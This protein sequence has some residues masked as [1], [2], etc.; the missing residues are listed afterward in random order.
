MARVK[1]LIGRRPI[2]IEIDGGV[3]PDTTPLVMPG[4]DILVA[5]SAVFKGGKARY[6][7]NID[8]IRK[9]AAGLAAA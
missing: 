2:Q 4:A 1:A 9:A 6:R 8:A 7:Q 5:G 3:T